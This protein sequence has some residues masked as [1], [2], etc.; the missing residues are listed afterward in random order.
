MEKDSGGVGGP[1]DIFALL[2]GIVPTPLLGDGRRVLSSRSSEPSPVKT[3]LFFCL[4]F[5]M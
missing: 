2:G 3:L 1:D 4:W 5:D